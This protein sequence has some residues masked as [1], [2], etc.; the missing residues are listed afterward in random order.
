[1]GFSPARH[2]RLRLIVSAVCLGTCAPA[3]AQASQQIEEIIVTS[4][5]RAQNVQEVPL[6][7]TPLSEDRLD[8]IFEAGDDIQ[9]L[10]TRVPS[11]YAESSNGRLAPRF[12]IRG[13]GNTDFDLA[14]SQPVS[15]IMDEVVLENVILKSSPLFDIERAEVL[16]GPQG[17]LFGRNTPAGIVKFDT[18]K[19]T[20]EAD[21]YLT[22][23]VG[24][25]YT[26][27]AEGALG[28][29]LTD[30]LSARVSV[31]Y[32][33][34]QDWV[35]NDFT[36]ES[37]AL[38]DYTE[39]A[40][41]LQ[42]FWQ[43]TD[44]LSALVNVHGRD[45]DG[46]SELFRANVLGPGTDG[47]NS[48][49]D[50]DTVF[51]DEGDN[52]PQEAKGLGGSLTIAYDLNEST[53]ITSITAH[54]TAESS[55]IGDIDGGSGAD[56]LGNASPCP[57]G[58]SDADPC[59]PF[60]AL[61]RDSI[62]NL[63]QFTQELRISSNTSTEMFWQ[64]GVYYFD[65]EFTVLTEPFFVPGSF[66]SHE[67]TAWALFGH[68]SYDFSDKWTLT[69]G[70][71]YTDD[72]KDAT[73]GGFNSFAPV[74][75]SDEQV[76]WD[77]SL[78]HDLSDDV[79]VYGRAA[80]GFRA[81]SIQGR[82]VAFFGA[83][84]TADSETILS[85]EGGVKAELADGRGRINGSVFYYT[86]DD[87]QLTAIGG[88][89]NSVQLVNADKG[90]GYG[91]DFD[92]EFFLS[93]SLLLTAGLSYNNTEIDDPNLRVGSCGSGICTLN[94]PVDEDGFALVDGNPFPNAPE[95]L[96]TITASYTEPFGD[97]KEFF[98]YTD[99]SW[100][101]EKQFLIYDAAEFRTNGDFE[102]GM[103]IGISGN[104]G[105]YEIAAFARNITDEENVK[106]AIDF[107]NLTGFSNQP[108]VVGVTFKYKLF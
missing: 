56:F 57:P 99:W 7:V 42:T 41:R 93:D 4:Q 16:R 96:W 50:R 62:G 102:G 46:T 49:F 20:Q 85:F 34:R 72:D 19:P 81:P 71:R 15:V 23:S 95:W 40:W 91:F 84:T 10:A 39:T 74:S 79:N 107:N 52:N 32:Q 65:S 78:L 1:M 44:A 24:S 100:Q 106:G 38:G 28:G 6:S 76:S 25:F 60:P 98:F 90:V 55:S 70:V 35:D 2:W 101:G 69:G 3:L 80:Y 51:Y 33:S 21:G 61:T 18:R 105:Q 27:N 58:F 86:I 92:A 97:G 63:D 29:G 75:V 17:T 14:A 26:V 48:N 73:T 89:D 77:I 64:A 54:E 13:L 8:A 22:A 66:V 59:I 11:L 5:R 108:R 87:Q 53:T 104:D 103:R 9:A 31:L 30:T 67:N 47:F 12:Y 82:D 83:P 45:Y 43:P 68:V 37:D 94:D 88:I 36:G